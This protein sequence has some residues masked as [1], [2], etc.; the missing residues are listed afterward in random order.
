[1]PTTKI[2]GTKQTATFT[3]LR[4]TIDNILLQVDNLFT[5]SERVTV[6]AAGGCLRDSILGNTPPK[7]IDLIIANNRLSAQEIFNRVMTLGHHTKPN[8]ITFV[9]YFTSYS[10]IR[11]A[12]RGLGAV[13]KF[14]M[15]DVDIDVLIY[16]QG[17]GNQ[18]IQALVNE[19]DMDVNQVAYYHNYLDE[20]LPAMLYES[21]DF[22]RAAYHK[23]LRIVN[24]EQPNGFTERE[25]ERFKRISKK[26]PNF[27][28]PQAMEMLESMGNDHDG[29]SKQSD[30]FHTAMMERSPLPTGSLRQMALERGTHNRG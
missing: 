20:A 22:V 25:I 16:E 26:L 17:E 7:D 5:Y 4:S 13:V 27:D 6:A 21:N 30:E 10:N 12:E 3:A 29:Y 23:E 28:A 2:A 19:F 18:S 11:V 14:K 8:G 15:G 1:M 24:R 9:N